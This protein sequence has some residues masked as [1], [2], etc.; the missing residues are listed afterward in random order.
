MKQQQQGQL[1]ALT[2][3]EPQTL[4]SSLNRLHIAYTAPT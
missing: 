3:E 4:A 1:S 2:I